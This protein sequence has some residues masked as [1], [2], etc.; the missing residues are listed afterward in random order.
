[1]NTPWTTQQQ[2]FAVA[3]LDPDAAAPPFL[4]AR[5]GA[6]LADRFDIYRNNVH[7]SLIEALQAAFPVCTRLVGADSFRAL[8]REFLRQHLPDGAALHDYGS[9]LPHFI[10][11][12]EPAAA[13]PWL[14]DVAA[15]EQ[16][17]WQAY[18]AADAPAMTV[19]EM[20]RLP[21][22]GFLAL[23]ARL[24]PAVR[25]LSSVHP[26]HS[27][28][29]AHQREGEPAEVTHW[30]AEC[31]LVTRPEADVQVRGIGRGAHAFISALAGG[32]ALEAAAMTALDITPDF[33]LGTTLLLAVEAGAVQ[34]LHP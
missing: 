7:A 30:E 28:W 34:E 18:G 9:Q 11:A 15:L 4:H 26:A 31:V 24:H 23:R 20:A 14:A 33:D 1:M 6:N 5:D 3:L 16:A 19:V 17:W 10:R 32:D 25:L 13:L 27:I 12:Y 29:A 8:S 21:G 2:A 22:A